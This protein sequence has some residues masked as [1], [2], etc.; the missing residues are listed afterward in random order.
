MTSTGLAHRPAQEFVADW[1]DTEAER[2]DEDTSRDVTDDR[3]RAEL[4]R[5]GGPAPFDRRAD[6]V[7][8]IPDGSEW[9]SGEPMS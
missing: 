2:Q 5:S 1:T 7:D 6:D 8:R 9:F 4:T 3:R